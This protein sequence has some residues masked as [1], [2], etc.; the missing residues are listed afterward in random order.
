MV[1]LTDQ[2]LERGLSLDN[3][4]VYD[5]VL[6]SETSFHCVI[7]GHCVELFDHHCPYINNCLGVRN[8]KWFL[9]FLFGYTLFLLT[10]AT[11]LTR[12]F[13][14][15]SQGFVWPTSLAILLVLN[16]PVIGF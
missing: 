3:I 16:A 12:H 9:M 14:D 7:C 13:L 11:E 5:E 1:W 8:H 6:K 4:C 2:L 15:A 10:L